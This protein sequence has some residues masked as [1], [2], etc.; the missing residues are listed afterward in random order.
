MAE[1]AVLI[2]A[3]S[4]RALAAAARRA[5]YRPLVA[6]LFAD[7]DTRALAHDHVHLTSDL[8]TGIHDGELV[9]A[10]EMLAAPVPPIGVVYGTGFEDRPWLLADLA[11]RWRIIGNSADAVRRTKDPAGFA[12]LCRDLHLPHPATSSEPP[13]DP[14]GWLIKRRGGAGGS[15]VGAAGAANAGTSIYF[16]RRVMGN[17]ISVLLLANGRSASV[18][19]LSAQ[20]PSPAPGYPFRYGGAVTPPALRAEDAVSLADAARRMVVAMQLVG[21]NSVDFII[22]DEG[23]WVLE[24]NPR[25]GATLD[26]FDRPN[27]PLFAWHVAACAG[28]LPAELP[29]L[30]GAM[31]Q[32]LVYAENQISSLPRLEWPDWT[33]DRQSAASTVKAGAPLCT[34]LASAAAAEEATALLEWRMAAIRSSLAASLS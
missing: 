6:D 13:L 10:L 4:G 21:L 3:I 30:E 19:G 24:I 18:L 28:E 15:H 31:A 1:P 16:Q 9:A 27:R 32:A 5:G 8:A 34:V 20:W 12:A 17:P 33:A 22:G 2:A 23:A 7:E 14:S 29:A 26:I 11:R 25:P